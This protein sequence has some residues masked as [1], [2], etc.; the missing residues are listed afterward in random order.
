MNKLPADYI[1]SAQINGLVNQTLVVLNTLKGSTPES[2]KPY[3]RVVRA[4]DSLLHELV[5]ARN[6]I[7]INTIEGDVE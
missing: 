1:E 7:A 5:V 6:Q 4:I 3:V 2:R